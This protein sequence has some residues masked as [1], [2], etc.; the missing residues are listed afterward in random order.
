MGAHRQLGGT[1]QVG[2]R[3][4]LDELSGLLVGSGAVVVIGHARSV[5]RRMSTWE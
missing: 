5:R 2:G 3:T 1:G 4:L